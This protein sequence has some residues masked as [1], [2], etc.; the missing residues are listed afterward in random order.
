MVRGHMKGLLRITR[1]PEGVG[2]PVVVDK[3]AAVV[4][5]NGNLPV[6]TNGTTSEVAASGM[7]R[8]WTWTCARTKTGRG[9]TVHYEHRLGDEATVIL[10]G[11]KEES[12]VQKRAARLT[13]LGEAAQQGYGKNIIVIS[14]YNLMSKGWDGLQRWC[15]YTVFMGEA[16]T[17]APPWVLSGK[18]EGREGIVAVVGGDHAEEDYLG[19]GK[20]R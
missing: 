4:T 5:A 16:Y 15:S 12:N 11:S 19:I 20:R 14:A 17:R 2:G 8:W 10:V 13:K 18:P 1:S 3:D 7:A 9:R 6:A